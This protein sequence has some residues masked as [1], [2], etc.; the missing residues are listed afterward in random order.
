MSAKADA[1]KVLVEAL[2]LDGPAR[3]FIADALLES[4]DTDDFAISQEWIDEFRRRCADIDS[5]KTSLIE[6][7]RVLNELRA[8]YSK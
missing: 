3:A 2:A 7:G 5:E 8:K 4:L 6:S 1:E